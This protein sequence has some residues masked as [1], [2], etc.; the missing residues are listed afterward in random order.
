ML[1]FFSIIIP[2]YNASSTIARTV[3][4]VLNQQFVNYE[5]IIVDDGSTDGTSL[6]IEQFKDVRIRILVNDNQG[7]SASRNKGAELAS[8]TYLIFL[9]SDDFFSENYLECTHHK[10]MDSNCRLAICAAN[11]IDEAGSVIKRVYP[12][13][14]ES[15]YGPL[16][17]G[18]YI[19]K[20]H[21]F[22]L[23]GGFDPK[24]FYSENSDLFLRIDLNKQISKK[25]IEIISNVNVNIQTIN[26]LSR[27]LK[28]RSKKYQSTLHFLNKHKEFFNSSKVHFIIYKRIAAWGAIQS[29]DYSVARKFMIEIIIRAPFSLKHY[30]LYFLFLFPSIALTYHRL[31]IK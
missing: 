5:I 1:P 31:R 29:G 6:I 22:N 15:N 18:S 8:G 17:C 28:Y 16:L 20:R 11:F 27:T 3:T 12:Y 13:V 21:L 25:D 30:A 7:P 23:M 10:L 4:S 19:M 24:L 2:V 26:P 14:N 9:D